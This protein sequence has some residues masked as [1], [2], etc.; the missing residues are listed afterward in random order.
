MAVVRR[1]P[2]CG[3]QMILDVHKAGELLLPAGPGQIRYL[4]V[5]NTEED[6]RRR[7][8]LE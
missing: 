8:L 5:D 2:G 7:G 6:K 1:H 4:I 3:G